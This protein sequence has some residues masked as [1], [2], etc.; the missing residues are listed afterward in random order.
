MSSLF[1]P[2]EESLLNALKIE[3]L[4]SIETAH[5]LISFAFDAKDSDSASK[6]LSAAQSVSEVPSDSWTYLRHA[7]YR[8]WDDTE[9]VASGS[10]G[11]GNVQHS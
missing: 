9:A 7:V 3:Q 5:L 4:K 8:K 11:L 6:F 1:P 2:I 10:E